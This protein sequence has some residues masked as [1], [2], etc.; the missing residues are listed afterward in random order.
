MSGGREN[1]SSLKSFYSAGYEVVTFRTQH[2]IG[3]H[4]NSS[5]ILDLGAAAQVE[6]P[7]EHQAHGVERR[8]AIHGILRRARF[9]LGADHHRGD[10]SA[11]GRRR[12]SP[13]QHRA[14]LLTVENHADGAEGRAVA[15]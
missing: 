10:E 12:R 1:G 7:V 5:W 6:P 13:T 2:P 3:S 14:G 4:A 8:E 11:I 9:D 15:D